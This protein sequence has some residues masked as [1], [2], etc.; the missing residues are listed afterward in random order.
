MGSNDFY[1]LEKK[2][3]M[4]VLTVGGLWLFPDGLKVSHRRRKIHTDQLLYS[5]GCSNEPPEIYR[6]SVSGFT[7]T[8]FAAKKCGECIDCDYRSIRSCTLVIYFS[9]LSLE[10]NIV[11][12]QTYLRI[13]MYHFPLC[14]RVIIPCLVHWKGETVSKMS[15]R[16]QIWP[17]KISDQ[18]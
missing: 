7:L 17:T 10:H 5:R 18:T 2:T 9:L 8:L 13:K 6:T 4:I 11:T 14:I 16:K 3:A 15:F 1:R 12:I